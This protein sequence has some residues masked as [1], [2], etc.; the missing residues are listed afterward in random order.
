MFHFP[1]IL[2]NGRHDN[3]AMDGTCSG[4]TS[5]AGNAPGGRWMEPAICRRLSR[6]GPTHYRSLAKSL[7]SRRRSG[8]ASPATSGSSAQAQP[9]AGRAGFVMDRAQRLRLR[10]HHRVVD[11]AA[12]R[13]ADR[14][15]IRRA[16]E[17][18]ISE[19]LA[20]SLQYYSADAAAPAA[21]TQRG[22][23]PS[24]DAIP[25]AAHQKKARDL[26][27]TLVFTDE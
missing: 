9:P 3:A 7:S 27:G 22:I 4:A 24:L 17:R 21:R 23:D 5:T 12:R 14:A 2:H 13:M 20:R 1:N 25:V 8:V 16:D 15:G 18:A 19:R 26:H 11:G 10:I 6:S